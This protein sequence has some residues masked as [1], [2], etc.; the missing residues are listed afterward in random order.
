MALKRTVIVVVV[1]KALA[2]ARA[3]PLQPC[4]T[5][6]GRQ[7]DFNHWRKHCRL[8]SPAG[9]GSVP[10]RL[11][12]QANT[13]TPATALRFCPRPPQMSLATAKGLRTVGVTT[14]YGNAPLSE[15]DAGMREPIG[16]IGR[17]AGYGGPA[18]P[19]FLGCAAAGR[20][21]L[22]S[23]GR[24]AAHSAEAGAHAQ[25]RAQAETQSLALRAGSLDCVA[26][27]H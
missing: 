22:D 16:E 15:T 6:K 5:D 27:G 23:G 17:H 12:A 14:V 18:I 1:F 24:R 8:F 3:L 13:A 26:V 20:Q 19:V 2:A 11:A 7:P 25:A 9:C 10:T 4:P 21:C